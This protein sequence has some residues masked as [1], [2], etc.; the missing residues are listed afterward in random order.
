[1]LKGYEATSVLL[2]LAGSSRQDAGALADLISGSQRMPAQL[3]LGRRRG[4]EMAEFNLYSYL[5]LETFWKGKSE[6][7]CGSFKVKDVKAI[8]M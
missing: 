3:L 2:D 1:M 8:R 7:Q 6:L 4:R 5:I